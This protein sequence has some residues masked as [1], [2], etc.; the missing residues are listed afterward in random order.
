MALSG[1]TDF[2]MTRAQIVKRAFRLALIADE[3][4]TLTDE[5]TTNAVENLN[6]LQQTLQNDGIRLW[7]YQ[8]I[9]KTLTASSEVTWDG[10]SLN[11]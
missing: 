10:D 8:W 4:Q 5:Q 9:T 7:K 11:Y 3:G 1:S 6:I 2:I